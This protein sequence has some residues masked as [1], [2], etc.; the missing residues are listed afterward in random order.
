MKCLVT[1]RRPQDNQSKDVLHCKPPEHWPPLHLWTL[2]KVSISVH[3]VHLRRL[4]DKKNTNKILYTGLFMPC[5]IFALLHM[6]LVLSRLEFARTQL[7]FKIR[8]VL[9]L[10]LTTRAKRANIKRRRILYIYF[11]SFRYDFF[12]L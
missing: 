6:Q 9:N 11:F 8:P 1:P 7:L 12:K 3:L 5:V 4:S 10:P 2:R